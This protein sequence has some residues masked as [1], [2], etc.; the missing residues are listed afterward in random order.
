MACVYDFDW[1]DSCSAVF[2]EPVKGATGRLGLQPLAFVIH[3]IDLPL[4]TFVSISALDRKRAYPLSLHWIVGADGRAIRL[5]NEDNVAIGIQVNNPTPE[6]LALITNPAAPNVRLIHI[7][8]PVGDNTVSARET[9]KN[10]ICCLSQKY[11]ITID[12]DSVLLASN[13]DSRVKNFCNP[14]CATCDDCPELEVLILDINECKSSGGPQPSLPHLPSTPIEV[15]VK[16]EALQDCCDDNK[17]AISA[18]QAAITSFNNS[19]TNINARIDALDNRLSVVESSMIDPMVIQGLYA[20]FQQVKDKQELYAACLETI[21]NIPCPPSSCKNIHYQLH[22]GVSYPG[23]TRM[24]PKNV[25]TPLAFPI[26]VLDSI[27]PQV[28]G[29]QP[30]IV[31][32]NCP[33]NWKAEVSVTLSSAH[34]CVGDKVW[35]VMQTSSGRIEIAQWTAPSTGTHVVTVS[36]VSA[37]VVPVPPNESVTFYIGHNGDQNIK[38]IKSAWMKMSC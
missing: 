1:D 4:E 15:L 6:A 13:F 23:V 29:V 37:A 10:L 38:E 27:P 11:S 28:S 30:T 5:V 26:K 36:T 8:I 19:I 7:G 17:S 32:L 9:V 22:P 20:L 16:L 3:T 33:C 35:I 18:L 34:Y 24:L 2:G 14:S 12:S 25:E 21:C 31:N